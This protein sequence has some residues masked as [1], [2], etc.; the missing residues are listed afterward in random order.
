[1]LAFFA[2][3]HGHAHGTEMPV[4]IG[5]TSYSIGFALA[6]AMLHTIGIASVTFLQKINLEK[7]NR[8]AGGVIALSGI[9]LAVS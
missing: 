5:A 8:F 9:Y 4:A 3:F 7:V 2:L 6:T 1:M